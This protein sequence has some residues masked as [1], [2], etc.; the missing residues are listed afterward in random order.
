MDRNLH[1]ESSL[2]KREIEKLRSDLEQLQKTKRVAFAEYTAE[3]LKKTRFIEENASLIEE[4]NRIRALV[5]FYSNNLDAIKQDVKDK[6]TEL[7]GII[8]Q[9]VER[10]SDLQ[11]VKESLLTAENQTV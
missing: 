3:N 10:R 8:Q 1:A 4:G 11:K 2:L 7:D 5:F 6:Q 9:L